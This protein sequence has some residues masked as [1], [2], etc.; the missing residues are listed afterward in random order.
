MVHIKRLRVQRYGKIFKPMT[1]HRLLPTLTGFSVDLD[2]K[3]VILCQGVTLS[4]AHTFTGESRDFDRT[5][6]VEDSV[7]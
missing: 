1:M 6:W 7:E 3:Q 2:K 4:L 5:R